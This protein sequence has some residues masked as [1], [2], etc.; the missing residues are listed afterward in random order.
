MTVI[1]RRPER[2]EPMLELLRE[3]WLLA[4]NWR[5][6]QLVINASDTNHNCG[7]VFHLSDQEMERRLKRLISGLRNMKPTNDS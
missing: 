3:A 5:L 4:P 1:P 6:T 2:I 7:P